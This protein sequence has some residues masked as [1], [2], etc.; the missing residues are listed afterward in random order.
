MISTDLF[1]DSVPDHRCRPDIGHAPAVTDRATRTMRSAL[2]AAYGDALGWISELT[3][4]KGLARRTGGAPLTQPIEWTRRIGGR[5]GVKVRLPRGC[6]SDDTQLRLATSRATGENGFDVE[7]FAKVE[8]SAWRA[9]ALG[10]GQGTTNA[11]THLCRRR[12][13]WWNNSFKGWTNSGGNGAAMRVQPHVWAA[14]D[15]TEPESYLVDVVRN[16]VCTHS[17]P[18]GLIGAVFHAQCVA[19]AMATGATPTPE[20]AREALNVAK[21]VPEMIEADA[22]LVLWRVGFET[23]SGDFREAW[24]RVLD[25][26][27]GAISRA[28]SAVRDAN[29]NAYEAILTDLNLRDRT[30]QGS[31]LLT[32]V[33]A[34]GLAW[35]EPDP[36]TAMS[37]AA[38]AVGSDTDTIATMAGA[39]V[40]ASADADPPVEVL[41]HDLIGADARRLATL[42]SGESQPHHPYPDLLH[43]TSPKAAADMLVRRN[44]GLAVMGLGA[45]VERPDQPL[46]RSGSFVWRWVT[47]PS[48]QT[49]L[50]KGRETPNVCDADDESRRTAPAGGPQT[51]QEADRLL[52][53][54]S[55]AGRVEDVLEFLRPRINDDREVGR[56]LRRVVRTGSVGE[57]AAVNAQLIDLLRQHEHRGAHPADAKGRRPDEA[58][59]SA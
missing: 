7:A 41:D 36:T 22:D 56:V 37:L 11:A 32:A 59:H 53:S 45:V 16:A 2:W 27:R 30:L 19:Q 26:A 29:G 10:G 38:N 3:D 5:S 39:I 17:H 12:T 58:D 24:R 8:L 47:L 40:G 23:E 52:G 35:T 46:M 9:Y 34:L 20:H 28:A 31:G 57:V 54:P 43:W 33:A 15:L 48:G 55:N 50:I 13:V 42:A 49:L 6:Y 1:S 4:E 21:R 14:S 25:E 51:T 18:H 44:G